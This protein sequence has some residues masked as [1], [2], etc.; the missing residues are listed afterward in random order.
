MEIMGTEGPP[1]LFAVDGSFDFGY[2]Q[3]EAGGPLLGPDEARR[4]DE[5]APKPN[6]RF[7]YRVVAMHHALAAADL[8]PQP[9]QAYAATLCWAARFA[10]DS[11]DQN[12]ADAIYKRYLRTGP[13]QGWA[14]RFGRVCPE[15]DF[16]AARDYWLRW[17]ALSVRQNK[18]VAA[19][20]ALVVVLL[21]AGSIVAIRRRRA[22]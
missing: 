3:K 19:G 13:Y 7:H 20:I 14:N 1:D 12:H 10:I 5:S 15:P 2:G 9:S 4:F 6:Q 22:A 17:I 21:I 16:E 11:G 18:L 8:L